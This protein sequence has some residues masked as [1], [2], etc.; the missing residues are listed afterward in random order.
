MYKHYDHKKYIESHKYVNRES[1]F[2][3]G[4]WVRLKDPSSNRYNPKQPHYVEKVYLG[5][6]KYP[7]QIESETISN[8]CPY[9]VDYKLWEPEVGEWCWFSS[10]SNIPTLRKFNNKKNE[11]FMTDIGQFMYEFCEPFIGT[12]PKSMNED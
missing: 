3:E 6:N 7:Q 2:K 4:D 5:N 11:L 8:I 1:I 10:G 12:L 9:S